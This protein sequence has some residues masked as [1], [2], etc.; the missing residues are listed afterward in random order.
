M[1][2]LGKPNTVSYISK[3][4]VFVYQLL[5]LANPNKHKQKKGMNHISRAAL[6]V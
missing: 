1:Q 3:V 6:A 5:F 4:H 2:G